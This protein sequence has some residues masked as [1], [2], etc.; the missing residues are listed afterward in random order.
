MASI[1]TTLIIGFELL[2]LVKMLTDFSKMARSHMTD[3]HFDKVQAAYTDAY[4]AIQAWYKTCC[5]RSSKFCYSDAVEM[6]TTVQGT[7]ASVIS[8]NKFFIL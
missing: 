4:G 3:N 8:L 5:E 7:Y 6:E 2:N 1:M